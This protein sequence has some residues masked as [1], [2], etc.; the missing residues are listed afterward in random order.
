MRCCEGHI[1]PHSQHPS[2]AA[3]AAQGNS[4]SL[5]FPFHH[6]L[7][8]PMLLHD[9]EFWVGHDAPTIGVLASLA[10]CGTAGGDLQMLAGTL[11]WRASVVRAVAF[12][13]TSACMV[14]ADGWYVTLLS[15][16]LARFCAKLCAAQRLQTT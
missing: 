11:A 3:H 2:H 9:G 7:Q 16:V 13:L 6:C 10:T 14:L 4:L 5:C 1:E 15:A 12:R 8:L